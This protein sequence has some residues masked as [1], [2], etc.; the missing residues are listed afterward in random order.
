[1]KD[2]VLRAVSLT[3]IGLG[4]QLLHAPAT[5]AAAAPSIACCSSGGTCGECCCDKTNGS[6]VCGPCGPIIEGCT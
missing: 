3:I 5:A 2:I 6:C 4:A 1:M